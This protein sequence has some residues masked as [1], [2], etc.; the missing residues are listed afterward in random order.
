MLF[1][2]IC[3]PEL[4]EIW[5]F[6]RLHG[7]ETPRTLVESWFTQ[8]PITNGEATN[9]EE[10]MSVLKGI[11]LISGGQA[12]T[13]SECEQPFHLAFLAKLRSY[14]QGLDAGDHVL[15]SWHLRLVDFL[16]I[17]PDVTYVPEIHSMANRLEVPTPLNDE[18]LNSWRRVAEWLGLGR[19]I[20][21]GFMVYY[22]PDLIRSIFATWT[23]R[24]G[25]LEDLLHDL[26]DRYLPHTAEHGDLSK[27]I[28]HPLLW[29]E[30]T[31]SVELTR[32][33]DSPHKTYCGTR[34]V[35][36]IILKDGDEH[37]SVPRPLT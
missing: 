4:E 19:K 14:S 17:L 1:R 23:Q 27:P 35:N 13:A 24:E 37:D 6:V 30:T 9:L 11:R 29:L 7:P 2:P 3:G 20:G 5:R 25:P 26:V 22:S 15:D 36:W 8:H 34:R 21:S 28:L 33:Q 32:R 18:K 31:G 16:F 10:A 12:L